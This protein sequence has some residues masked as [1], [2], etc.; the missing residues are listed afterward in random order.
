MIDFSKVKKGTQLVLVDGRRVIVSGVYMSATG[1]SFMVKGS[2]GQACAEN[3]NLE[4]IQE[5]VEG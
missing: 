5:I 3:I 4:M 1:I 2:P